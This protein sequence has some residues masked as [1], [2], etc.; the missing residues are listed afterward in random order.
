MPQYVVGRQGLYLYTVQHL[1]SWLRIR[2]NFMVYLAQWD[3]GV[4]MGLLAHQTWWRGAV[5]HALLACRV[6]NRV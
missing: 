1:T 4:T 3:Y 2:P 6:H 5:A